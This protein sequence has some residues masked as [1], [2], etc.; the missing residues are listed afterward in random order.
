MT[1]ATI[2]A[3]F[4]SDLQKDRSIEDQIALCRSYAAKAGIEVVSLHEDRARSSA[5]IMGRDGLLSLMDEAR[6]GKFDV[7]IVEALDRFSRDQEDLA[8]I[9][10]R[11]TFAGVELRAVHDG[12]A[13]HVQIG[14]RGLVGALFLQ[15]LGHKVRRGMTGVVADGRHAGGRAYGYRPKLGAPGE[16]EIQEDEADV[17]RRIFREYAAGRKPREIAIGLNRDGVAPPR[18]TAWTSSTINGNAKRGH[19]I[20]L[21]P[22]YRGVIVWNR[23]RMVKDPETGRRV[24]RVNPESEW[25]TAD[26][27]HLRL[28][29]EDLAA[30]ALGLKKENSV[31]HPSLTRRP[32]RL[33]SGLLK[34][35]CCRGGCPSRTRPPAAYASSAPWRVRRAPVKT[36]APSIST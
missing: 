12:K 16:M 27:P 34:C 17:V 33:L 11:L 28:I 30:V 29:D 9:Y 24:S 14:I 6:E 8:G 26:A 7:V 23:V 19:G 35:G 2:Y 4:S 22:I 5:S 18:G 21:N 10:K 20:I 15:D 1:R 32:K 31:A 3:R 13:D 36:D 25:K